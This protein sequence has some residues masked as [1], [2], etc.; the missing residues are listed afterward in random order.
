M[1]VRDVAY[2]TGDPVHGVWTYNRD[3]TFAV[4]ITTY[5]SDPGR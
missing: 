5:R 1:G 2:G 4:P 3:T